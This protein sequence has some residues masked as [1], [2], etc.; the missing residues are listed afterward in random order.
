[1]GLF[2]ELE[3]NS[4]EDLFVSQL[5]DLYDAEH[6]ILKAL[7]DVI[8]KSATPSLKNAINHHLEQTKHHVERLD[9]VF[10]ILGRSP[11]GH[12]CE[13]MKGLLKEGEEVLTAKGDPDVKDA[14]II[15]AAQRVEHYEMAGYGAARTFAQQLGYD[16]AAGLLQ[17]TLEEEK[18]A[19][20]KLTEI[21]ESQINVRTPR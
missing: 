2:T 12:T 13:A 10:E 5:E 8:E 9:Q 14:A 1:M 20:R 16:Q 11:E 18:S 21:A 3:L 4:L 17:S 7:P 19:D 6:R 15:A